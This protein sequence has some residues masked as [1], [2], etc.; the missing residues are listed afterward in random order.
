[1]NEFLKTYEKDYKLWLEKF[2][3][4]KAFMNERN[5]KSSTKRIL[6]EVAAQHPLVDGLKPNEEFESRLRYGIELYKKETLNGNHVEFYVPG[7]LHQYNG[8][9]DKIELCEA[10][11]NYLVSQGIPV[12]AI[13]GKDLNIKYKGDDG[14]YNSADECFVASKY[15]TNNDFNYL[16]SVVSPAQMYRKTLFYIEFGVLPL[17]FSA[18]TLNSF[19]NYIDEMFLHIPN[20]L[21][22]DHSWQ[23]MYEGGQ[24]LETRKNRN[25]NFK[26]NKE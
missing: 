25:P 24:A 11:Q 21:F 4:A 12:S 5:N 19:H 26:N 16:F 2:N 18:P 20:V 1:M 15:F 7:S 23:E 10:G 14:V 17:N 6:I 13:H 22:D 9:A 8:V 3:K